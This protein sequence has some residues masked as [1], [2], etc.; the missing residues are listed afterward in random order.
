MMKLIKMFVVGI[1]LVLTASLF[2]GSCNTPAVHAFTFDV[3]FDSTWLPSEDRSRDGLWVDIESTDSCVFTWGVDS[4]ITTYDKLGTMPFTILE[5]T[6]QFFI[7]PLH[8]VTQSS[9]L[10]WRWANVINIE[11]SNPIEVFAMTDYFLVLLDTTNTWDFNTGYRSQGFQYSYYLS[12]QETGINNGYW[13]HYQMDYFCGDPNGFNR[14]IIFS[15]DSARRSTIYT[16]ACIREQTFGLE[17][18]TE[19]I[20][21]DVVGRVT[22]L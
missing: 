2:L 6:Y 7:Y 10:L 13:P 20:W 4:I 1:F 18:H 16:E 14:E 3:K 8:N 15:I 9:S 19:H 22:R 11:S 17:I 21:N 5:G 12:G